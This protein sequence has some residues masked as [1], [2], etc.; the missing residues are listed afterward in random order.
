[1]IVPRL[2]LIRELMSEKGSIYFHIDWHVGHYIKV[3]MDSIFG[4]ENFR[5]EIILKR[6]TKNLL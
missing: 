5:N 2:I 1:M 3:I 6:I 4:R